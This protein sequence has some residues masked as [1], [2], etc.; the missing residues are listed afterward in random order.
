MNAKIL[1]AAIAILLAALAF[2]SAQA[3]PYPDEVLKFSQEPMLFTTVMGQPYWGHDELSTAYLDPAVPDPLYSGKFMADD[4]ADKFNTPVTHVTWWGS[5]IQSPTQ[6]GRVKQFL[7]SFEKDVPA[8]AANPFS[9]PGEPILSQ[10]VT[11]AP[12][13]ALPPPG[14]FTERLVRPADPVLG[15]LVFKYNAE[16][17]IPFPELADT[18]YWL[19]IVAL[20]NPQEDGP[21]Q[22]GWHN[23]DYTIMDPLASAPPFVIP[24]EHLD[25]PILPDGTPIWHFQDDAVSGDVFIG[26]PVAGGTGP[27]VTQSAFDD[28]NYTIYDGPSLIVEHSKDLAF[29]LHTRVPEPSSVVLLALGCVGLLGVAWRGRR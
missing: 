10:I 5:Y 23:R 17:A 1:P 27:S 12:G 29:Q 9:H 2:Q 18:V 8:T 4:F 21:I 15:E 20:V 19:K 22:W 26:P 24:G 11:V 25:L 13:P 6:A 28:Q 16:L 7:I 14:M 3:D